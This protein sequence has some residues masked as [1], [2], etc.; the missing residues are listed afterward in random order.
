MPRRRPGR[1]RAAAPRRPRRH[2][3]TTAIRGLSSAAT[4]E[5]RRIERQKKY[6]WP[7]SVGAAVVRWRSFV[8]EP[9]RRLWEYE[10]SGCTE[11][12]CCGDPWEAREHLEVVM[13]SMSR[14]RAREL[15]SLVEALDERY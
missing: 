2:D 11:W 10:T 12:A 6:L 5:V 9:S 4:A 8:D 15:R 1:V 13:L 3:D 7:G 14:R